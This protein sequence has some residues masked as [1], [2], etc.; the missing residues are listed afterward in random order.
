MAGM[1]ASYEGGAS[2]STLLNGSGRLYIRDPAGENKHGLQ[3]LS[4]RG[5]R[6]PVG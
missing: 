4:I 3:S 1:K 2:M 6:L 5:R